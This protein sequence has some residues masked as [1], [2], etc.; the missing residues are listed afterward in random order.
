MEGEEEVQFQEHY[1]EEGENEMLM[2]QDRLASSRSDK[3][4]EQR[5]DRR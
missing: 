5:Y 2:L 1:D 4:L 3:I